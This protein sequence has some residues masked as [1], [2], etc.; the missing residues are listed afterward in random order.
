MGVWQ[1]N[2]LRNWNDQNDQNE[3]KQIDPKII[4]PLSKPPGSGRSVIL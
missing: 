4:M 1:I 2:I 3:C